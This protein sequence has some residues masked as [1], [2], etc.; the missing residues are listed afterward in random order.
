M[1]ITSEV[2]GYFDKEEK[3]LWENFELMDICVYRLFRGVDSQEEFVKVTKKQIEEVGSLNYAFRHF[4]EYFKNDIKLFEEAV[5]LHIK[6][7][8][9]LYHALRNCSECFEQ[10]PELHKKAK[11]Y[12]R[13]YNKEWYRS[14]GLID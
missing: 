8:W 13:K 6:C 9:S 14:G 3:E 7:K 12:Q 10:L 11:L 4:S 1:K 5:K 2:L